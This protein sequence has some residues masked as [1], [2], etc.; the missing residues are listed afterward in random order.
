MNNFFSS[1]DIFDDCSP[2]VSTVLGL[3]DSII[4]EYQGALTKKMLKLEHGDTCARVRGNLTALVW[5]DMQDTH[6]LT[7]MHRPPTEGN[8]CDEEGKAQKPTIVQITLV[9]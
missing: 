8:F 7:N 2:E 3:L 9:T 6:I 1:Q 5:K 4:R